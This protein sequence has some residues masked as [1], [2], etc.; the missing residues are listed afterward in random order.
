MAAL[1]KAASFC[2]WPSE[3]PAV[4]YARL[5]SVG[6]GTAQNHLSKRT[7]SSARVLMTGMLF[8]L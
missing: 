3:V 1:E 7:N 4:M 8:S 6:P 5:G 2:P